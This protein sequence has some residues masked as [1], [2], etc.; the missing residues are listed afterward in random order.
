[1]THP[2]LFKN[3]GFVRRAVCATVFPI[4]RMV[5]LDAPPN[6]TFQSLSYVLLS[7][8]FLMRKC[9]LKWFRGFFLAHGPHLL[10]RTLD[11]LFCMLLHLP[12]SGGALSPNGG[13]GRLA[14][15]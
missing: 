6:R 5:L 2:T 12:T 10:R 4:C 15:F 11:Y 1:M 8:R 9:K 13:E 7:T 14:F 3:R